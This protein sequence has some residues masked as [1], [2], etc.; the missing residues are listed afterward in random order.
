MREEKK[1]ERRKKREKIFFF[2]VDREGEKGGILWMVGWIVQMFEGRENG[3]DRKRGI[4]RVRYYWS[5]YDAGA[6]RRVLR[7]HD[8]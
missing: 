4:D 3:R 6:T 2:D 7:L 1:K 8:R 5:R